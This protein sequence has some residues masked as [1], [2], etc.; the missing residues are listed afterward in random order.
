MFTCE[1]QV[2]EEA[3]V[4]ERKVKFYFSK[5][6][7]LAGSCCLSANETGTSLATTVEFELGLWITIEKISQCACYYFF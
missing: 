7:A 4:D 3:A 6:R 2:S 5:G 1:L